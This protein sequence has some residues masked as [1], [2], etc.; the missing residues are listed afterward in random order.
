M[1]EKATKKRVNVKKVAQN[2]V[3]KQAFDAVG[4]NDPVLAE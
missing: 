4:Q 2:K 3:E 1:S